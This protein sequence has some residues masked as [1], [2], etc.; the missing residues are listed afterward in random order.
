M[1]LVYLIGAGPGDPGLLTVKAKEVLET[2]DVLIYDYLAN[3][4]FLNY[5][6]ADCEILYVG[7][8]AATTPCRRIRSTNSSLKK[9][10]KAKLSPVL[11]AAILM[12]SVAAAKKLKSLLKPESTLKSSPASPQALPLPLT[13]VSR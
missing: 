5:C 3:I 11:K 13:Q 8:K 10:R 9:R 4:E 7:K 2:A 1:G 12:F 6:K